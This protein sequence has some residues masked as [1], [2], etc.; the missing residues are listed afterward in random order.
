MTAAAWRVETPLATVVTG[1]PEGE[2]A[3]DTVLTCTSRR[4]ADARCRFKLGFLLLPSLELAL[5]PV[6]CIIRFE[7]GEA[8]EAQAPSSTTELLVASLALPCLVA[9]CL[10]RAASSA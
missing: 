7:G 9:R 3:T 1:R 6:N 2:P 10:V 4:A 5:A 8:R